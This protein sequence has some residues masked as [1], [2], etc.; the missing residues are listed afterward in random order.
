M[1]L[2]LISHTIFRLGYPRWVGLAI[3]WTFFDTTLP[4]GKKMRYQVLRIAIPRRWPAT[5]L[6]RSELRHTFFGGFDDPNP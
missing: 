2:A 6:S 5:A 3:D 1:Q 4:S